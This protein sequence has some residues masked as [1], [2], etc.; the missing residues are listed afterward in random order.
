MITFE[1]QGEAIPCYLLISAYSEPRDPLRLQATL[2]VDQ[3]HAA[4]ERE[5][6]GSK[7]RQ[8][9]LAGGVRGRAQGGRTGPGL[10]SS[11]CAAAGGR[12][13]AAL[14]SA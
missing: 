3:K 1:L 13:R 9:G 10:A 8:Q 4:Y 7:G 5:W 14:L 6:A 2:M 11:A 12:K